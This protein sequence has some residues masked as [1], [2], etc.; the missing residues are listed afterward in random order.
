MLIT[1]LSIPTS[2]YTITFLFL[3]HA[4]DESLL[5]LECILQSHSSAHVEIA[6]IWKATADSS[7]VNVP[8]FS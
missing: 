8:A 6:V 1:V 4:T 5:L 2:H 3:R 7:I